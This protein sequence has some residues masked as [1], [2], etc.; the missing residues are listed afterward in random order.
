MARMTGAKCRVC[1]RLGTKLFLRGSRCESL[2][3]AVTRRETP[4]GMHPWGRGKPTEYGKRFKEKQKIR[5]TYGLLEAQFRRFFEKASRQKGNTGENLLVLLERRLDNV[6][7]RLGLATSRAQARQIIRHGH[8]RVNGKKVD[9][10]SSQVDVGDVVAPA[11]NPAADKLF[12]SCADASRAREVPKWLEFK[13]NPM[14][15]R[16]LSLPVPSDVPVS[17]DMHM[18]VEFASR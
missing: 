18:V 10:P 3:C 17:F 8:I 1:R 16:V 4:P 11:A 2:K 15:G 6:V 7:F 14:S 13:D 9:V 12:R 5:G